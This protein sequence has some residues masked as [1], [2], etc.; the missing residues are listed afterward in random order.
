VKRDNEFLNEEWPNPRKAARTLS[1]VDTNSS[2]V[3]FLGALVALPL[4]PEKGAT[5]VCDT[6][7]LPLTWTIHERNHSF[8]ETSTVYTRNH[9]IPA[10]P[11]GEKPGEQAPELAPWYDGPVQYSTNIPE[12]TPVQ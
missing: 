8:A 6:L 2:G 11:V 5:V 10:L 9:P 3:R 4:L 1:G 12:D 7:T